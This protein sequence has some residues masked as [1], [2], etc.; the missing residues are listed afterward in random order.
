MSTPFLAFS[1]SV[2]STLKWAHSRSRGLTS[3]QARARLKRDGRNEIATHE[4]AHWLSVLLKQF[5][6][7]FIWILGVAFA[8]SMLTAHPSDAVIIGLSVVVSISLSFIQEWKANRAMER[9]NALIEHHARV[10]R[11]SR[12]TVVDAG[13][14]VVGDIVQVRPGDMIVAD[15]RIMHGNDLG[16]IESIL[17]GE[18]EPSSKRERVLK[19]SVALADRT[20][21]LYRGT[22]VARG[23][24]TMVVT[25]TGVNTEIGRIST[26][27]S[28]VQ[29]V[30][31]P[32]QQQLGVLARRFSIALVV[33]LTLVFGV[34]VIS[35][36]PAIDMFLTA[37]A[38]MVSAVPEGLLPAL[39]VVL[40]VGMQKLSR[41]NALV[42]KMAAAETLG[43]ISV[44]CCDKTGT[45]TQGEMRVIA[46][47]TPS[48]TV[49]M[50]S[51]FGKH[52]L[53]G[54]LRKLIESSVLCTTAIVQNPGD[55]AHRWA[56][57]GDST[58]KAILVAGGAA[59]IAKQDLVRVWKTIAEVP[60]QS[61][62]KYMGVLVA[63]NG[64]E[65]SDGRIIVKGAPERVL[66]RCRLSG[67]AREEFTRAIAAA[68]NEGYR[69]L[70]VATKSCP[71]DQTTLDHEDITDLTVLGWLALSD[72]VRP[73]SAE[74]IQQ[75]AR[76]G[77]RTIMITGDHALT[78]MSIARTVGIPVSESSIMQGEQ[79]DQYDDEKLRA[80]VQRITVFARVEPRH[81]LRIV[82]A[83]QE[84]GET[85]AMTGDGVN[86]APSLKRADIGV[87]MGSGTDVAKQISALIL[88]DNNISTIVSAIHRGRILYQNIRKVVLYLL[89]DV[90]TETVL[91]VGAVF[92]GLPLPLLP[93]QILWINLMADS[94]PAIALSMEDVD[95]RVMLDRPRRR[96]ESIFD[97][98][99]IACVLWFAA[100][101]NLTL[102]AMYYWFVERTSSDIAY[103]RTMVFM[104][105]GL[106]SIFYIYSA[107]GM[108]RSILG[109]NPFSNWWLVL[110]T[111]VSVGLLVLPFMFAPVGRLLQV[112]PV[113]R[114][115]WALLVGYA[116][117][118]IIVFEVGKFAVGRAA[119][120]SLK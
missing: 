41:R 104:A 90:F 55:P 97:V 100:V 37:V 8:L 6:D 10:L 110:S 1:Q 68:T 2:A 92:A 24:A 23:T 94:T 56:I 113:E 73:E 29:E 112:V 26:L 46:A 75:V 114:T 71:S 93:A 81:K 11:D 66:P 64:R 74:A 9:L 15:G 20:N 120:V 118:G 89:S 49:A 119:V 38:M 70:L 105:F 57:T 107:R 98:H 88:L 103:A 108:R 32:L 40:A 4:T 83:L 22:T 91:V 36:V 95:E 102:L 59:G 47:H 17:T 16:V 42:R 48:Q 77:I 28:T 52:P 7:P 80:V 84:N 78:A 39:T 33:L 54:D 109:M 96:G 5:H 50:D 21:M 72:P 51:S 116:V 69:V 117:L 111:V 3:A 58:E 79:L 18:S 65:R 14:L 35:G 106:M 30:R 86:D 13:D 87:A 62:H 19:S 61:S 34:G 53:L 25:A 60:F 43:N 44:L 99:M 67:P 101:M 12:L 82:T 31:T 45:L 63:P 27:V 76:A 115:D 85:V